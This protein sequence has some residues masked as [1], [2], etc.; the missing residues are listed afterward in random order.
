MREK[1]NL[2]QNVSG[3]LPADYVG[4]GPWRAAWVAPEWPRLA[5]D[6]HQAAESAHD[7]CED[8]AKLWWVQAELLP[9]HSGQ[10]RERRRCE[11]TPA[12]GRHVAGP[13]AP[14]LLQPEAART[15]GWSREGLPGSEDDLGGH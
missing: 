6:G 15:L 7:T 14:E 2:I 10:R 8:F 5:A 4:Q 3:S 13:S 1:G 12:H 9:E 11:N